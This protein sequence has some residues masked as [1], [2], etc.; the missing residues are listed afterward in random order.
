MEL[1]EHP[2][3]DDADLVLEPL[4]RQPLALGRRV[5]TDADKQT[6]PERVLVPQRWLAPGL[7]RLLEE[8][9]WKLRTAPAG[10]R[11]PQQWRGQLE[12]PRQALPLPLRPASSPERRAGLELL[13]LPAGNGNDVWLVLPR[14][15]QPAEPLDRARTRQRDRLTSAAAREGALL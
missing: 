7:H 8:R 1:Q 12:H 6:P 13:P 10:C 9:G 15:R 11:T 14:Q 5:L 2:Q 3:P 4:G